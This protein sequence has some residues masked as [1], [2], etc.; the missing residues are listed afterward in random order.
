MK[1]KQARNTL[2]PRTTPLSSIAR[3]A[4][5]RNVMSRANT[6][7][8]VQ[9]SLSLIYCDIHFFFSLMQGLVSQRDCVGE[10]LAAPVLLCVSD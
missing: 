10:S 8:G 1:V 2:P 6:W 5:S 9:R 4:V 3:L 7:E